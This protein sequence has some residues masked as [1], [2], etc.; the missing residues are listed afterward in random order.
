MVAEAVNRL[1]QIRLQSAACLIRA[2]DS[3]PRVAAVAGEERLFLLVVFAHVAPQLHAVL[4]VRGGN[5]HDIRAHG[6]GNLNHARRGAKVLDGQLDDASA[7]AVGNKLTAH[8]VQLFLL[9]AVMERGQRGMNL[10][11][12]RLRQRHIV[13][14]EK[15]A[16]ADLSFACPQTAHFARNGI[17]HIRKQTVLRADKHGGAARGDDRSSRC[18]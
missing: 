11:R 7:D 14:G 13:N 2:P 8:H 17:A 18:S 5:G 9:H 1:R 12:I 10:A 6:I 16:V 15:E 4:A 3:V